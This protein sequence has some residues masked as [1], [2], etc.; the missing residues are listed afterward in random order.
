MLSYSLQGTL[1]LKGSDGSIA[2]SIKEI[3][4]LLELIKLSFVE[5][6]YLNIKYRKINNAQGGGF[7]ND[8]VL[9]WC[10]CLQSQEQNVDPVILS[11]QILHR[12]L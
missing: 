8:R 3:K 2:I 11:L 6:H 9:G 12:P 1:Q 5:R 10:C 4:L 7:R